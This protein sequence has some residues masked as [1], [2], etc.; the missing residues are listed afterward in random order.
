MEVF[1][2]IPRL[3]VIQLMFVLDAIRVGS[4]SARVVPIEQIDSELFISAAT[5]VL[6]KIAATTS[7]VMSIQYNA[8]SNWTNKDTVN[9]VL[10]QLKQPSYRVE[11]ASMLN[12]VEQR[13]FVVFFVE[14]FVDFL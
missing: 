9:T 12:K 5:F 10:G 7:S 3:F 11:S 13:Q 4:S 14:S 8:G 1:S 6:T 2:F